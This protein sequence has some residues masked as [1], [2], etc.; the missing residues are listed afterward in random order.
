MAESEKA[1]VDTPRYTA[2]E[3]KE[4]LIEFAMRACPNPA[5]TV[6]LKDNDLLRAA[7]FDPVEHEAVHIGAPLYTGPNLH[8][9]LENQTYEAERNGFLNTIGDM[10]APDKVLQHE[11][12]GMLDEELKQ[13]GHSQFLAMDVPIQRKFVIVA[14]ARIKAAMLSPDAHDPFNSLRDKYDFIVV[15]TTL[16]GGYAGTTQKQRLYFNFPE[17]RDDSTSYFTFLARLQEA[18][19]LSVIPPLEPGE[20]YR[21]SLG[22][23]DETETRHN[24]DEDTGSPVNALGI[25]LPT[26]P[27]SFT[28]ASAPLQPKRDEEG[29]TVKDGAWIYTSKLY[30]RVVEG[31]LGLEKDKKV[32]DKSSYD[33]ML[34]VLKSQKVTALNKEKGRVAV[35]P[36]QGTLIVEITHSMDAAAIK[37]WTEDQEAEAEEEK[38]F[39]SEL[40]AQ[41][42]TD[43][44]IGE[45]FGA[46]LKRE[47]ATEKEKASRGH[48][49]EQYTENMKQKV[50]QKEA[51]VRDKYFSRY[52]PDF[53]Q[54]PF[55]AEMEEHKEKFLTEL[56][57]N[58]KRIPKDSSGF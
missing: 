42:F 57:A 17:T 37:R 56:K 28:T 27:D 10:L 46:Y 29:Y 38:R 3:M 47:I 13:R 34:L 21:P 48:F 4:L 30:Q 41:G 52:S 18:T 22:P 55:D 1:D 43:D 8:T 45:P 44:D 24:H 35:K 50:K 31:K 39:C 32:T 53:A 54:G 11:I 16:R 49:V 23:A 51:I 6:N 2:F 19:Q 12:K 26:P 33:N 58:L 7:T 25:M 36:P 9:A 5:M 40:Q 15:L 14:S 20:P